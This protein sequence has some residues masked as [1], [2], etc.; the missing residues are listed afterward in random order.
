MPTTIPKDA[1]VIEVSV[2]E[3]HEIKKL[4]QPADLADYERILGTEDS[5]ATS[6]FAASFH[7]R[8]VFIRPVRK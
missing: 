5:R 4:E 8:E 7:D 3:Y 2:K 1:L 6:I